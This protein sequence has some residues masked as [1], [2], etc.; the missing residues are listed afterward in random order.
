VKKDYYRILGVDSKAPVDELK[1]AYHKLAFIYHPDKNAGDKEAEEHFK[2]ILEAYEILRDEHRRKHYDLTYSDACFPI[3]AHFHPEEIDHYF[4]VRLSDARVKLN[5]EFTVTFSYT[6]EG[7]LFR[8]P[9]FKNFFIAGNPFVS[10]R[11]V[12][13][14][15][16]KVKETSQKYVLA[17]LRTGD[18]PIEAASIKINHHTLFT[19]PLTITVSDNACNYS[20][21]RIADGNPLEYGLHFEQISGSNENRWL[22]RQD[23]ILLIPRSHYAEMYHR[24]GYWMKIIY[25]LWGTATAVYY[26]FNIILGFLAGSLFGSACC[27]GMYAMAGVK[28]KF[29]GSVNYELLQE[30]FDR[31]YRKG[32]S[33][34]SSLLNGK[35][36]HWVGGLMS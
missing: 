14:D 25:S 19:D 32:R 13:I 16:V 5:E 8:K 18:L 9:S 21:G 2:V 36:L 11:K 15:G 34:G 31:G 7:R 24:I 22:H 17:P 26:G 4:I 30:Y 1:K 20:K 6:G 10:F 27:Y 33:T 28:S 3:Y 35:V 29:F 12:I 23:H